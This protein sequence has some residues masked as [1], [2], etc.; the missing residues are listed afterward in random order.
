MCNFGMNNRER[1]FGKIEKMMRVRFVCTA[2]DDH[3]LRQAENKKRK[4]KFF[5]T[6]M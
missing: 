2:C 6:L 1:I 3:E 4:R 5:L